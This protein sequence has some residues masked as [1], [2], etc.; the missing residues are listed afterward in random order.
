MSLPLKR[1]LT[2]FLEELAQEPQQTTEVPAR[3]VDFCPW[4]G[5]TL[6]DGQRAIAEAAYDAPERHVVVVHVVGRR[7]GKTYAL[8]A[9][10]L[11][12]G[13]LTRDVSTCAPGQIPTAVVIAPNDDLRGESYNYALGCAQ[14]HPV[15]RSWL[16]RTTSSSFDMRRPDGV[17]VRFATGVATR[18]G[19]G[20]RGRSLTDFAMDECAFFRD[21]AN[22][23]NDEDIFRAAQPGVLPGGQTIVA[24]SPWAQRG[25]LY[26]LWSRNK[27]APK[28][29]I[30]FHAPTLA[31]RPQIAEVVARETARD[32]ENAAREFGAQFMSGSTEVFFPPELVESCVDEGAPDVRVAQPGETI[33]AGADFGFRSDSSALVVCHRDLVG[34][35]HVGEVVELRP[36]PGKPLKPSETVAKF[37]AKL[38][39]HGATYLIADQHYR[40]AIVEHL[41]AHELAF[42]DAPGVPSDAY[43][44]AK[45]LMREGR[46]KLPRNERLLRQ[47]GE[48]EGRATAGGRI[49]IT[50]PRWASGGHCDLASA[51]VLALY[52]LGGD[53]V[54]APPP[55][56]GSAEWE[57]AQRAERRA[58]VQ[59]KLSQDYW[60]GPSALKP[61]SATAQQAGLA[62]RVARA[63]SLLR[64][65]R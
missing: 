1:A 37:A 2:P 62:G 17:V 31:L 28:D 34:V 23:V 15:M 11:L 49:A 8:L 22:K 42:A 38:K 6:T 46:V 61:R 14:A 63:E 60:R 51:L 21:R 55:P 4:A 19:Y 58:K 54:E 32:P 9:I 3:Y 57:E 12:H 10:R 50:L 18:G 27:D 24:S 36:E 5:V 35:L 33:I 64:R 29:A 41:S 7:G 26:E 59:Q 25:L 45:S 20:A 16:V 39:A 52:Q 13:M 43:V 48:V 47:L 44:R 56:L 53:E 65:R 30:V 40:E